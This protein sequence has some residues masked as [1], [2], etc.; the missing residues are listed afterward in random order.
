MSAFTAKNS[1]YSAQASANY[2]EASFCC[3]SDS[4]NNRMGIILDVI[5]MASIF[6]VLLSVLSLRLLV[7]AVILAGLVVVIAGNNQI[8]PMGSRS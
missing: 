3:S 2:A 8:S 1:M 7:A 6:V 4:A 5:I